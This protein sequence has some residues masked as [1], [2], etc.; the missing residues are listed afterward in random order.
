MEN[1]NLD[2][3]RLHLRALQSTDSAFVGE[4]IAHEEVRRFLGGPVPI[5]QREAVMAGCLA[6]ADGEIVW[7]VEAKNSRQRLGLISISYHRDGQD[8]ELS[9]QFHPG[10]WGFGYATEAARRV[11]DYALK[12]LQLDRLI[13]ETQSA[14]AASRR[15]L[16]RVGMREA[17]RLHR[18]G[19]EQLIY[20][21]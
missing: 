14:N 17:A 4:L 5:A 15:L 16:E 1:R 10:A 13:A 19:A 11:L 20:V 21:S 6:S 3:E 12:E 2:T 9:Y 7:L 18:F 8:R